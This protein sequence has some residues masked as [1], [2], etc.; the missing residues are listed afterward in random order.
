MGI[1]VTQA[2][3]V[4]NYDQEFAYLDTYANILFEWIS[5]IEGCWR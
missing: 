3:G 5:L 1:M 2:P 4:G